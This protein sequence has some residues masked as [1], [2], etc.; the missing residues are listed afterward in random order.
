MYDLT[1]VKQAQSICTLKK[2]LKLIFFSKYKD[3]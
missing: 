3:T 2:E 1:C